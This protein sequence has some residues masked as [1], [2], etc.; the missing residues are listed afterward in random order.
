MNPR[1]LLTWVLLVAAIASGWSV[2]RGL[3]P[4]AQAAAELRPDYV[5]RDYQLV[6]LDRQGRESFTLTGPLLQRAP[7]SRALTLVTP[8]FLIP[9]AQGHYWDMRSGRG[10]VP[11]DDS[12]VELR[13][14]VVAVSPPQTPTP[15]R[16]ET[17]SLT[18][19]LNRKLARSSAEVVI[20]RPG[21]TMR[22]KGLEAD[23]AHQQV[24]LLSQVRTRYVPQ[25]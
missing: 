25:H 1:R 16:I 23:L 5:L 13:D 19:D 22:G 6:A 17:A 14:Q 18:I 9:D 21:L 8:Q 10:E 15:T 20:T 3:R 2:W 11:A 7:V 4:Q 12:R 24:S